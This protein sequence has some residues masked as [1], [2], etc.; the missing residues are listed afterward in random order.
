VLH[1]GRCQQHQEE[2]LQVINGIDQVVEV[3]VIPLVLP[4]ESNDNHGVSVVCDMV[5]V[6]VVSVIIIV[7][8]VVDVI[9][10]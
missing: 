7:T 5:I 3:A 1:P 9:S 4:Q 2:G 10:N 6:T 8:T